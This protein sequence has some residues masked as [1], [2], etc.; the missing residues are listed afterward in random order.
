M[1]AINRAIE[2]AD[3]FRKILTQVQR[4]TPQQS[5]TPPALRAEIEA[6]NQEVER[7]RAERQARRAL[8]KR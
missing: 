5:P 2:D 1:E 7:K 6:W 4:T 8:S 3:A